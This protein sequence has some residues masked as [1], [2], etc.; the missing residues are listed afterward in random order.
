MRTQIDL[1]LGQGSS[2]ILNVPPNTSG[3]I[4]DEYTQQLGLAADARYATYSRPVSA[5][6]QPV[7][8]PCS[9]LSFT[10]PVTGPFDSLS[11]SE[12]LSAGQ[13]LCQSVAGAV[14]ITA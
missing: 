2:I 11:I 8:G 5:L 3:L 12:D 4:P 9:S 1:K 13:V 14:I 6:P 7:S 10:L